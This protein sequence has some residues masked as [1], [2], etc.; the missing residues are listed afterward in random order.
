M[1]EGFYHPGYQFHNQCCK[2]CFIENHVFRHVLHCFDSRHDRWGL[3]VMKC[4]LGPFPYVP[5]KN[6]TVPYYR[7]AYFCRHCDMHKSEHAGSLHRCTTMPTRFTPK[8][9]Y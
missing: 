4:A 8:T 2:W 3:P 7:T 6:G 9:E 5:G 1:E